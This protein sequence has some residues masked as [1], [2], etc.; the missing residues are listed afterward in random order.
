VKSN[1]KVWLAAVAAIVIVLVLARV[2]MNRNTKQSAG[3]ARTQAVVAQTV[4]KVKKQPVLALTGSIEAMQEAVVSA[5]VTGR[6]TSVPVNNGDTV[7]SGQPLVLLEDSAYRD[8]L[9]TSQANLAKAQATLESTRDGYQRQKSLF[10]AG[11]LSASDFEGIKT[12]LALAEADADSAAASVDSDREALQETTICSPISGVA[13]DLGVEVGEFLTPGVPPATS[14]LDVEDIS[15]VYAVVSIEQDD[16]GAVSPGQAAKVT[17]DAYGDR[18]FNGT[19]EIINPVADSST[20]AFEAKIRLANSDH[21][22]R[23]G[24]FIK[25][26]IDTGAPVDVVAAP[27][28][29]VVSTD[30]LNYV[31]LVDGDRVKRQQVQVGQVIGQSVEIVSG[32]AEGQLVVLTDVD[33]LNDGDRVTIIQ[34]PGAE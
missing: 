13:A 11:A 3:P 9:A 25:V 4:V 12:S 27:Q 24:M 7:S 23:P 10:D 33:T 15:S 34:Q 30:G 5:E 17:V 28:N 22:L 21:L 32:L 1:W 14:L 26:E 31:F 18:V 16:V 8:A 20:R 19:V 29:A 6:V 2:L